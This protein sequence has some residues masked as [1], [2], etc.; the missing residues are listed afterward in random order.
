MPA[1][2]GAAVV[3]YGFENFCH[4]EERMTELPEDIRAALEG[5]N[6]WHLATVNPDGSPQVT[7]VWIHTRNGNI[8]VNSALGR[9]KPR[10]IEQD[11]R[12][13]LSWHNPDGGGGGLQ[14]VSIQGRVVET[15]LD[16]QADRDIDS[17]AQKYLGQE[18]YPWRRPDEQRV[19]FIIEPLRVHT[20]V[21]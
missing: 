12:V 19:T 20:L 3:A 6:F 21:R 15:I 18:T 17:L 5:M 10:N 13:A 8:L 11:P 1:S 16:G 2:V 4:E 14:S 7:T 9:K